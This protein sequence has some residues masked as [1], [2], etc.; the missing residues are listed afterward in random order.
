VRGGALVLDP[1][2]GGTI[3]LLQPAPSDPY[4]L[5]EAWLTA[6]GLNVR[7]TIDVNRLTRQVRQQVSGTAFGL[8][9]KVG[10]EPTRRSRGTSS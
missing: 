8:V 5:D 2:I 7:A 10:F 4:Q 3:V 1:G 6:D 9:G